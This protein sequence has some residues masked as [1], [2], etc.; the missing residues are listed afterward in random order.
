MSKQQQIKDWEAQQREI[1]LRK[2]CDNPTY[3][4]NLVLAL[5]KAKREKNIEMIKSLA[6]ELENSKILCGASP[7]VLAF[8]H[9]LKD[10]STELNLS[11]NP[12]IRR[13]LAPPPAEKLCPYCEKCTQRMLTMEGF[14]TL[15]LYK[16]GT[17]SLFIPKKE[18]VKI[19]PMISDAQIA[20]R[21]LN[22]EDEHRIKLFPETC[23]EECK[24][25]QCPYRRE[26]N[27]GKPC[28]SRLQ[29]YKTPPSQFEKRSHI[30]STR[31]LDPNDEP[32]YRSPLFREE[33]TEKPKKEIKESLNPMC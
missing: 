25:V 4:G 32:E 6:R 29:Q 8:E 3:L 28:L 5:K 24:S 15:E 17:R 12:I 33:K 18:P 11:N 23:S 22:Y 31:T 2:G 9:Q 13:S 7:M 16:D 30:E 26:E 20:L 10:V 19:A 1:H 21:N 27:Y 14:T